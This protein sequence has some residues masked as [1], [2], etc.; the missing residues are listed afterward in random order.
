MFIVNKIKIE[1]NL[2]FLKPVTGT[3]FDNIQIC[4]LTSF[5]S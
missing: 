4:D 1:K 2:L 3:I 5:M